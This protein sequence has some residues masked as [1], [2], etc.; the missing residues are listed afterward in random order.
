M[1]V[2]GKKVVLHNQWCSPRDSNSH[3]FRH[4][5]LN[6]ACLPIPPGEQPIDDLFGRVVMLAVPYLSKLINCSN[7]W[8]KQRF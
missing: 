3:T 4:T 6:R 2:I 1:T 8:E 7:H 5:T